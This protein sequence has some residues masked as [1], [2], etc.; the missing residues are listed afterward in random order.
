MTS[1]TEE[2]G[3]FGG[4]VE[5]HYVRTGFQEGRKRRKGKGWID[6]VMVNMGSVVLPH[7]L[8]RF[9]PSIRPREIGNAVL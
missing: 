7:G 3:H 8:R 4:S 9:I 5:K 2:Q 1:G 6:V